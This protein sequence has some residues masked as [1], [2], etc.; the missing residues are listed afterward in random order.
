MG[1]GDKHLLNFHL[2]LPHLNHG[3]TGKKEMRDIPKGY[4]AIMVGQGEEQQR[5]VIPIFYFN[6]P[7]F[8][9][10]LK[11]AEDEYGFDQKGTITIPCHVEEFRYV[12]G[13]ID[14]EKSFH[15]HH[16]NHVGCFRA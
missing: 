15:H 9:Q 8:M 7:L 10:L 5:F 1:G 14:K 2:H 6:H 4:L 12:Q 13:I 16:H 3:G 11:E